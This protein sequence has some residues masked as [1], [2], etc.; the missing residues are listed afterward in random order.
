MDQP[1]SLFVLG[2]FVVACSAKVAH[3]P[4]PGESLRAEAFTAEPGGKGLNLALGAHRLGAKVDGI[5]SIGTDLFSQLAQ[6][7]FAHA[8][9]SRSMLRQVEAKTGS[10]IGFT[11][12]HGENCL[13]VCPGANLLLSAQDIRSVEQAVRE[14]GLVLAQFE[15]GDEPILEAFTIADAAG[16]PTVLNPS[17][18]RP[19]DPRILERTSVLVLNRVEAAHLAKSSDFGTPGTLES[20]DDMAATLLEQGPELIVVTL[21][22]EGAIA[23]PR[24]AP[25]LHQPS[26]PVKAID[27]LGAGDAF[28]AGLAVGLLQ[29]RPLPE[30][31]RQAAACGAILCMEV[32]V[33]DVLPNA[34]QLHFFL[35][36]QE[37]GR[38]Q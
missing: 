31:L 21:G 7:A 19:V 20:L 2:S 16:A 4:R 29:G 14:A 23:Y 25:P 30:C 5:F 32:G 8:G 18:Y 3:L 24:R 11:D 10:G 6:S 12:S 35:A 13:A 34:E 38:I 17:P 28:T 37:T 27:S 33:F 9:L 22:S 15:I 1:A 36:A 26:F